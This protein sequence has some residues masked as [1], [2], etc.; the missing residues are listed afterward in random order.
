MN[1]MK[2]RFFCALKSRRKGKTNDYDWQAYF[3][4]FYRRI[5]YHI[6]LRKKKNATLMMMMKNSL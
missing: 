3:L 4:F 5:R 1:K 6:H 2:I